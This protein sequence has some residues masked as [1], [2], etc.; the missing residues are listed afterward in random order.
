MVAQIFRCH[1]IWNFDDRIIYLPIL[2]TFGV[3]GE[4]LDITQERCILNSYARSGLF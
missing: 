1:A 4:F 2:L 3:G